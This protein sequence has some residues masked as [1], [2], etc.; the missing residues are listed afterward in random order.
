VRSLRLSNA[1]PFV[2]YAEIG[3]EPAERRA[4]ADSAGGG[5]VR[6][7]LG[8]GQVRSLDPALVINTEMGEVVPNV[9]ETLT[10]VIEGARVV[11][12][13]ASEFRAEEG[14]LRFRFRL[15]ENVR[16]HDGRRLTARDV[17]YTFER[18]L[19]TRRA[20]AN[21]TLLLPVRGARALA[22]GEA[23][24]LEGFRIHSAT[25]FS[26]ELEAPL[27]F[28]SVLL[29]DPATAIV[30]EGQQRFDASWREQ[31]AGTGAFRVTAFEPG[32]RVELERNPGYWREGYPRADGL[33]FTIGLTPDQVLAEFR[34]GRLS[35]AS[36]LAPSDVEALR[37][38]PEFAP[39]YYE[40]PSLSLGYLALN[41][42][43]GP[44]A[45][46][47]L[48]RRVA[49]AIDVPATVRRALGR[50]AK[51]AR[52]IIPPGL[53]GHDASPEVLAAPHA[54]ARIEPELELTAAVGSGFLRTLGPLT[55]ELVDAFRAAGVRVRVAEM[56]G[57]ALDDARESG[58]VDMVW[59]VWVADY[60]DSDGVVGAI[61]HR[62]AGA[63]G[64]FCGS[65]EADRLIERARTET[66]VAA[67]H[68]LYRQIEALVAR[69]ALMV[70]ILHPNNYRFA[71]PEVE[72]VVCSSL[73]YPVVAY[74]NLRVR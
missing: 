48:R 13:L 15:R 68:A 25:E 38:D 43:S 51:P 18:L 34:G 27:P 16:F 61:L 57:S 3:K 42:R 14:G 20:G 49:R 9:F 7:A 11:P 33:V 22:E 72:G 69:D 56:S 60:P 50:F 73:S 12:W 17:R 1:A 21:R 58:S 44:L 45:D 28:F 4:A 41:T 70:P 5:T 54:A 37:H 31:C 35:L 59:T 65:E 64:R 66:D 19:Q 55:G 10:R 47:S 29:T 24:D 39:R 6:V 26:V 40:T 52:G 23:G 46:A 2:N 62:T 71:R 30:P 8:S 36:G 63:Y 32:A 67:R 74:E 53:V